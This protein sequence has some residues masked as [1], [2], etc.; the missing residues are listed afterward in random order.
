MAA[1]LF[2]LVPPVHKFLT[3]KSK[4]KSIFLVCLGL[5]CLAFVAI[6]LIPSISRIPMNE[7]NIIIIGILGPVLSFYWAYHSW[8]RN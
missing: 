1:P 2:F 4:V 3:G 8:P 5:F 6:N 7:G